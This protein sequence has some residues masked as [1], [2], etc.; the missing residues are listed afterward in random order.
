MDNYNDNP[1][2][3]RNG[4]SMGKLNDFEF[5]MTK[6]AYKQITDTMTAEFKSFDSHNGIER[7]YG[8]P[9]NRRTINLSGVLV[10][11]P[12]DSLKNL[13]ADIRI[14][15]RMRFTTIDDDIY[16]VITSLKITK[17]FFTDNG[18]ATVQEYNIT[19]KEVL[20]DLY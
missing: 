16:C 20:E 18:S 17:K 13:Q 14:G 8:Q 9:K 10:V 1:N 7:L 12:L 4:M 19:L 5:F 3:I 6:N 2:D 15:E 11:Q